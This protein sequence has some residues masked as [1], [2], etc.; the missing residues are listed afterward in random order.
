MGQCSIV[1][2]I[3][4]E[5]VPK[6]GLVKMLKGKLFWASL[7]TAKGPSSAEDI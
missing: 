6:I 7:I 4:I 5:T 1:P 2:I 3:F